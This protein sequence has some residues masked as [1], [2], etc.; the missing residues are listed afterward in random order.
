ALVRAAASFFERLAQIGDVLSRRRDELVGHGFADGDDGKR[1]LLE[2]RE[3]R[4]PDD[5]AIGRGDEDDG[6][7][8][9]ADRRVDG[10]ALRGARDQHDVPFGMRAL[11][12]AVLLRADPT[13]DIHD[14]ALGGAAAGATADTL[15]EI[16]SRLKR[17]R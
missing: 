16:R 6:L 2:E 3:V 7:R 9:G 13:T 10:I 17:L 15:T 1:V 5:A 12:V 8:A 11:I 4:R 14:V